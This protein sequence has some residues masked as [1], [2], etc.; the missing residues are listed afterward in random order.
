MKFICSLSLLFLLVVGCKTVVPDV[1]PA[2]YQPSQ[3]KGLAIAT[4]T[5]EGGKPV[6]DIYRFF[7]S[8]QNGDKKFQKQNAG[9]VIINS[10]ENKDT[11]NGDFNNGQT[12]LIVIEREPGM[13]A[14]TQY[15]YLD[16][17]G[18]NGMVSS[19]RLFAIPFEIKK[20][21]ITYIGEMSYKDIAEKGTPRIYIA[22]YFNRDLPEFRKKYPSVNW[23]KA[24]NETVKKGDTG[25][26]IIDFR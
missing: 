24:R 2:T 21:E 17:I 12:Y 1:I 10:R 23:D 16:R 3:E 18:S 20:G 5:F 9:K 13:Y 4:L 7:Y 19:S 26:G 14:F 11:F 8:P 15:N 6:N 25:G 22:D